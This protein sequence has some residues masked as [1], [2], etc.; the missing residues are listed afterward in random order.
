MTAT[1]KGT[2]LTRHSVPRPQVPASSSLKQAQPVMTGSHEKLTVTIRR[3]IKRGQHVLLTGEY[4]SGRSW[5]LER[6]SEEFPAALH[7]TLSQ[8]KR[9]VILCV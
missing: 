2:P 4:G 3:Q 7:L 5:M 9:A 1:I 6:M 8:S